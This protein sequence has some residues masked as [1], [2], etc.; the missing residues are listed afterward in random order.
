MSEISNEAVKAIQD[1]VRTEAISAEPDQFLTRPVFAPP[2]EA[3]AETLGVHTLT[4]LVDYLSANIDK[5]TPE[6]HAIHIVSPTEVNLVGV[7]GGRPKRRD[8]LLAAEANPCAFSFGSF[9]SCEQ[10][11]IALQSLFADAG[12]RAD[13]LKIVGN[14][15]EE[16]VGQFD[17]DG[18]TQ[19]VTARAGVARVSEVPVPNPVHLAP[20]RTFAEVE[21]PLSPFVLRMKK[22]MAEGT[23][24]TCAL[25]EADG[26][27]WKL[28]AIEAVAKYLRIKVAELKGG[29]DAIAIIA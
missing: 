4:G 29:M 7:L 28:A 21:Q 23:T 6:S 9:Q 3:T 14:I 15:K 1:S 18:V 24:P 26:A 19:T 11:N 2:V 5:V 22:G 8:V 10:F 12:D 13:V 17:D 25:F 16:V 20:Y 27:K